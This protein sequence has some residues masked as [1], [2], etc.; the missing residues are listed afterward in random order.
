MKNE[1]AFPNE[2]ACKLAAEANNPKTLN[3]YIGLSKR[4]YFAGLVLH[5]APLWD[6]EMDMKEVAAYAVK[7]ADALL[8]ELAK[9]VENEG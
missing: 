2:T 9:E 8:A 7:Y 3:S 6:N 5:N 1:P 4:E